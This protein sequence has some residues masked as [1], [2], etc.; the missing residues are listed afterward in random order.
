MKLAI[1]KEHRLF[2]QKEGL[3]EFEDFLSAEQLHQF[4]ESIDAALATR[5]EANP[6][7]LRRF[8]SDELFL[9]GRD[10]SRDNAKLRQL[11]SNTRFAEVASELVEKKPIRLGYDQFFPA[12]QLW[13]P[14]E[15]AYGHF[16]NQAPTLEQIS[17]LNEIYSGLMLCLSGTTKNSL[18]EKEGIDIFPSKVGHAI[19]FN[20]TLN[21]NLKNYQH[22]V[23]H[24][25]LLI[26]YVSMFSSYRLQEAD[27]HGHALKR[28]GYILNDKLSDRYHPIIYR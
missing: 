10:L 19:Y 28:L 5:L 8:R 22:H 18:E 4:N 7:Q 21:L 16:L 23:G 25:Y 1:A 15:K 17:S 26:V 27:P 20:P 3:I 13:E 2:Y 11:V 14:N 6:D 12:I 9:Q 24:R